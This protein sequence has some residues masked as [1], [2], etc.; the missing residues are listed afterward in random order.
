MEI[1]LGVINIFSTRYKIYV[2]NIFLN[3]YGFIAC[4][5]TALISIFIATQVIY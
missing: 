4:F 3:H 5:I 2:E 1:R